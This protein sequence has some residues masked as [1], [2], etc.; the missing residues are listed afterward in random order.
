MIHADCR[1]CGHW[2]FWDANSSKLTKSIC[3]QYYYGCKCS[4]KFFVP[5]DNLE[6]L[7]WCYEKKGEEKICI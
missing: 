3:N 4:G 1:A 7:E 6:Y 5:A 2:H